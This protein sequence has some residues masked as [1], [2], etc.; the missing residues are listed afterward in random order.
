MYLSK[1]TRLF[2][3]KVCDPKNG[4][5]LQLQSYVTK[6]RDFVDES[7]FLLGHLV[8]A[9][10]SNRILAGY[11]STKKPFYCT[12]VHITDF[13][14]YEYCWVT[15]EKVILYYEISV[16]I[17]NIK[18][19][20][21]WLLMLSD[22][23]DHIKQVMKSIYIACNIWSQHHKKSFFQIFIQIRI[24]DSLLGVQLFDHFEKI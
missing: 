11:R 16:Y 12:N 9:A 5:H 19:R 22:D 14:Q 10:I 6:L 17:W 4:I 18:P 15:P 13:C 2:C 21:Y 23:W 20:Y 24:G 1:T 8:H 7:P 3:I